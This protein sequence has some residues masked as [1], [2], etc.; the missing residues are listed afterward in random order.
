MD[1]MRQAFEV[2]LRPPDRMRSLGEAPDT[3][4][5]EGHPGAGVRR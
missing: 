4:G 5:E 1:A 3:P 2:P